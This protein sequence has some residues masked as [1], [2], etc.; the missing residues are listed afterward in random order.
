MTAL[1]RH[2]IENSEQIF[3]EKELRASVPNFHIHVSVS[4]LYIPTNGSASS[5]AGKNVDRSWEYINRAQ[6][7][8]YENWEIGTEAAQFLIW[9]HI[10][11][12]LFAVCKAGLTESWGW[13][14]S[15]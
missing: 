5:D 11:G 15:M 7:P 6:T 13:G 3:S 8:E 4:D 9:E 12:F 2:N 10:N 14:M 1:Q